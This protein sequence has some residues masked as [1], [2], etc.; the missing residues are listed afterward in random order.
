MRS[1]YD[2]IE[3]RDPD[4]NDMKRIRR[5]M[6]KN[7]VESFV[8]LGVLGIMLAAFLINI[9]G[10]IHMVRHNTL[11]FIIGAAV[12]IL[13]VIFVVRRIHLFSRYKVA[14]V[15]VEE[16]VMSRS[17][18]TSIMATATVSQ[19]DINLSGVNIFSKSYPEVGSEVL[20]FIENDDSWTAGII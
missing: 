19:G 11:G 10:L 8:L 12:T 7:K 14:E 15:T 3:W 1:L 5:A 4:E 6:T 20:L 16:I 9:R 18:E 2:K 17:S 13:F